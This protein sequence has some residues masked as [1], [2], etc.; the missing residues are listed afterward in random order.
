MWLFN[1][2]VA[3]KDSRVGLISLLVGL[4]ALAMSVAD[5]LRGGE[6]ELGPAELADDLAATVRAQW[7]DEARGRGLRDSGVLPL[8]WAATAREVGDAARPEAGRVVRLRLD[9]RLE[10][11]F[12]AATRQLAEEYGRVPSGRLIVLGE[13]GA[14]KS[15]LAMLLVL[16]LL[17]ACG[18]GDPLPVL[19]PAASWD[20][21]AETMDEWIVQSLAVSYYN[22]RPDIPRL[23]AGH[24]LL[25]PVLDGLDE[26]PESVRRSAVRGIA[27]AI[28]KERP[29]VVT[30]RSAE[31]EDVIQGGVPALRRAPVVEVAPVPV[32]DVVAYLTE[33]DWPPGTDWAPVRARLREEPDGPLATALSTPLMISLARR[34]YQ[35]LGGD[36]AELL[37]RG[38]FDS[39]HAVEDRLV[40]GAVDAA[41]APEGPGRPGPY[42]P[43]KARRWLIFL[44]RYLHRNRERDLAWW[45]LSQRLL[46]P[47][48]APGVGLACGLGLVIALMPAVL[49]TDGDEGDTTG[50]TIA[51]GLGV[52]FAVL[53]VVAWFIGSGRAPGRLS[54]TVAG[55]WGR[56]RRGFRT[57]VAL[58]TILLIPTMIIIAGVTLIDVETVTAATVEDYWTQLVMAVAL[59]LVTGLALAA[60]SWLDAPPSRSAQ[61]GPRA[62]MDQDRRSS[63]VG[64]V[65]AGAVT[66]LVLVPA[67]TLATIVAGLTEALGTGWS[68]EPR[69]GDLARA[70][71]TGDSLIG[72]LTV[73]VTVFV[74]LG[75]ALL[76]LLTRAWPRF[77]VARLVLAA[78]GRLPVRLLA[79]L[80]HARE[81]ELLRQ[82]GGAYQFQHIRV[83]EWLANQP[84]GT[85]PRAF[86]WERT[87]KWRR[88]AFVAAL[89]AVVLVVWN[90]LTGALPH[91]MS[92]ATL[93]AGTDTAFSLDG[94]TLATTRGNSGTVLIWDWAGPGGPRPRSTVSAGSV[95]AMKL[96]PDG[97]TLA[98]VSDDDGR[99]LLVDEEY[100]GAYVMRTEFGIWLWDTATGRLRHRIRLRG[101]P[102]FS[103]S[104]SLFSPD[105]RFLAVTAEES[106]E[107][108]REVTMWD[109]RTGRRLPWP[110][111]TP[112]RRVASVAFSPDSRTLAAV[113]E[114]GGTVW[115]WD[116]G[117]GRPRR[118][119]DVKGVPVHAVAW[120]RF[121]PDSRT[122]ATVGGPWNET[123]TWL[124][125]TAT[126][127]PRL[128]LAVAS[129]RPYQV[130]VLEFSADSRALAMIADPED[131]VWD[132][133]TGRGRRL[134]P[135][136]GEI[137]YE[138]HT[139]MFA[140]GGK[141]LVTANG[142]DGL[143]RW[144]TRTGA[145]AGRFEDT[146]VPIGS[147]GE[148]F[149]LRLGPDSRTLA[150]ASGAAY[151]QDGYQ[152]GEN[153][154]AHLWDVADGTLKR[155]L[156]GHTGDV[157]DV[158]FSADGRSVATLGADG[159]IKIWDVAVR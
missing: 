57:G 129:G 134:L 43:A 114:I 143:L 111:A 34:S 108:G 33:I 74:G 92:R 103:G 14:G 7:L 42:D 66:T 156:T 32:D 152:D 37:D 89:A 135:L 141:T 63:L 47:W 18:P 29:V 104:K 3:S 153:L 96:S 138:I 118:R 107:A 151:N 45:L 128:R 46:S 8:A 126:G 144:D 159:T 117:T 68:G 41:Y 145:V 5:Y 105:S 154:D 35:R 150:T 52:V 21:V 50:V 125:D 73:P 62:F 11:G 30:C 99:P 1:G 155:R 119:L 15:V 40:D 79:F 97:R 87:A 23:L 94:R 149:V 106:P 136:D 86:T 53:A 113:S 148:G 20:P 17:E 48:V 101:N 10:A 58:A 70:N 139:V 61:A 82:S 98:T 80:A 69:P 44:A 112:T 133:T 109:V 132:L 36:P 121:S 100:G 65:A 38:R 59:A 110:A 13:P 124:W 16:G 28:G 60:H 81:Q 115:L 55:T 157:K 27:R 142:V 75:L 137:V 4:A 83:Q 102:V 158:V 9:G 19:L 147:S 127:E 12:T 91:D 95:Y 24:G 26:I 122:L 64:A 123:T 93:V 84:S 72:A 146:A 31:Y 2:D 131:R 140:A 51:V 56:L 6:R 39:R 25:L 49:R 71:A 77:L 54:F 67:L 85:E 130:S 22:G 116:T 88:R 78:R 120:L 76:I 90:T